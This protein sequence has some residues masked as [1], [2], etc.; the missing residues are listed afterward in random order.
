MAEKVC[1]VWVGYF[2]ASPIR[3]LYQNP[4]KILK[5]YLK[6]GMKVI[7]IGSAM[8]FFSIPAAKMTGSS[9]K[10]ICIDLQEK[11]LEQLK[12]KAQK[13]KV[14]DRIELHPCSE[15]SL[16]IDSLKNEIDLALAFAVL[17]E[18]PDLNVIFKEVN[19]ALKEK[20]KLLIAEP[21]G[22]VTDQSFQSTLDVALSNGFKLIDQP[23]VN[24]SKSAVLEK[25]LTV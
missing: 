5:P 19:S 4:Y 21:N 24:G 10:V 11:M 22:H 20:A 6:D 17:H 12:I 18:M 14:F 16:E 9:G 8:G 13:A 7:D 1:P 15:N 23:K 3:K 25:I 2:L